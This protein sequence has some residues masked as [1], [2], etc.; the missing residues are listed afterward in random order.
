[1]DDYYHNKR[2]QHDGQRHEDKNQNRPPTCREF[3]LDHPFL[4]LQEP[5][6]AQ[7]Q[8]EDAD[9]QERRSQWFPDMS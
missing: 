2:K 1:M 9:S 5:P 8:R 7:Y 6:V 3:A 4:A